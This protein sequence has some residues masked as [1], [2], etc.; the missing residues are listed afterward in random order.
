[1][2]T[3]KIQNITINYGQYAVI[4]EEPS[5]FGSAKREVTL[6]SQRK[7][8]TTNKME[9]NLESIEKTQKALQEF[10]DPAIIFT[11][12][13]QAQAYQNDP[14]HIV[15][16]VMNHIGQ[17]VTNVYKYND[18]YY[19]GQ[20]RA[21][22]SNPVDLPQRLVS[23]TPNDYVD[24]VNFVKF[25]DGMPQNLLEQITALTGPNV[26]SNP[27]GDYRHLNYQILLEQVAVNQTSNYQYRNELQLLNRQELLE[28]IIESLTEAGDTLLIPK[29]SALTETF[30]FGQLLLILGGRSLKN[31][32]D[33]MT[34]NPKMMRRAFLEIEDLFKKL[35]TV[36]IQG[37]GKVVGGKYTIRT[38]PFKV[39][40]LDWQV[41]DSLYLESVN[42]D[43]GREDLFE[44]FKQT[45]LDLNQDIADVLKAKN[46]FEKVSKQT[47]FNNVEVSEIMNAILEGRTVNART[48]L[49]TKNTKVDPQFFA[50]S[51]SSIDLSKPRQTIVKPKQE[52]VTVDVTS[53]PDMITNA[54]VQ[55]IP[56]QT[57][58]QPVQQVPTQP[59]QQPV[60]QVQQAPA[61]PVQDVQQ[62]FQ[63]APVAQAVPQQA[64]VQ[65]VTQV[66]PTQPVAETAPTQTQ[67]YQTG[68]NPFD[69]ANPFVV[70]GQNLGDAVVQSD[71]LPF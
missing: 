58:S 4:L 49:V 46:L 51:I 6:W 26:S 54:P 63:S 34:G 29:L 19:F 18:R 27:K 23:S 39:P 8:K 47:N 35:S 9:I 13:S 28:T 64:P 70:E 36:A 5:P 25:L 41:R 65:A 10:L 1:M 59:V 33:N 69:S 24:G 3:Y 31:V 40:A 61:Q 42:N 67:A 71:D 53:L 37:Y 14:N 7:N 2:T 45:G 48:N 20:A 68:A 60:Q 30:S 11:D 62:V 32:R 52:T 44:F 17:E 57:V 56:A 50:P 38:S 22:S 21:T 16:W 43:F 66:A 15:N 55:E 12:P